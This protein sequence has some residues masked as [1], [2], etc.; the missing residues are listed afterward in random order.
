MSFLFW[1]LSTYTKEVENISKNNT[2]L[3]KLFHLYFFYLVILKSEKNKPLPG[4]VFPDV[5]V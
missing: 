4:P 2:K 1:V 3:P 5:V